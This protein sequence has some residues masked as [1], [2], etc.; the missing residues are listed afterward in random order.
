MIRHIILFTTTFK[1]WYPRER[2]KTHCIEPWDD[3]TPGGRLRL[4]SRCQIDKQDS[5]K[6]VPIAW[7]KPISFRLSE[8]H[9]DGQPHYY[10]SRQRK[11]FL[12]KINRSELNVTDTSGMKPVSK[13]IAS[14][15][16][17]RTHPFERRDNLSVTILESI[18]VPS[19]SLSSKK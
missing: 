14:C 9:H 7:V 11:G 5:N 15:I 6:D 3:V 1:E 13:H 10:S 19:P 16:Y 8:L 18:T 2:K 4:L 12:Y 17:P